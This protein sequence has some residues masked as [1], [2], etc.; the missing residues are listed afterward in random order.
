MS[1]RDAYGPGKFGLVVRVV[2]TQ[3]G[4]GQRRVVSSIPRDLVAFNPSY[5]TCTYGAGGSTR[6]KTL[7]VVE[8]V[9]REFGPARLRRT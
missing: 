2:S 3:D 8:R 7:D 1:L 9:R 4:R 6:S 5:I